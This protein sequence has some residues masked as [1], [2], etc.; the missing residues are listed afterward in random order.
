MKI[1]YMLAHHG[2]C[3]QI[4]HRYGASMH[5]YGLRRPEISRTDKSCRDYPAMQSSLKY[6]RIVLRQRRRYMSACVKRRRERGPDSKRKSQTATFGLTL[7]ITVRKF[8][9]LT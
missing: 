7:Q 9:H 4:A 2:R 3:E 6:R 5:G 1:V 8:S